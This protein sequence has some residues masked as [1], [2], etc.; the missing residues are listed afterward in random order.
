MKSVRK[1]AGCLFLLGSF[2]LFLW[3][4]FRTFVLTILT[5]TWA[6]LSRI[7]LTIRPFALVPQRTHLLFLKCTIQT[8]GNKFEIKVQVRQ[9]SS[10]TYGYFLFELNQVLKKCHFSLFKKFFS[11]NKKIA[12]FNC[13]FCIVM[14]TKSCTK[15][16]IDK[17]LNFLKTNIL[18]CLLI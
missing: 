12:F 15:Q 2:H 18:E 16:E 10:E 1:A 8:S 5:F 11:S 3:Y 14:K 7:F 6:C 17:I 9:A 4:T 13:L